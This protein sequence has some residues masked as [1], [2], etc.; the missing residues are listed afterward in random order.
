MLDSENRTYS[1][2]LWSILF[3]S[4][5]KIWATEWDFQQCGICDQQSL[6]SAFAY[7]QSDQSL[8]WLLE[9]SMIIKLL[10]EHRVSKL[11]RRRHWLVWVYTCQNAT[12]L[13]ITYP[14]SIMYWVR[15]IDAQNLCLIGKNLSDNNSYMS[16]CIPLCNLNS[17]H[18]L[19]IR[20]YCCMEFTFKCGMQELQRHWSTSYTRTGQRSAV[21][22]VS[23]YRRVSDCRS[24]GRGF[25]PGPANTLV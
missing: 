22:N 3:T 12:L 11:K 9:Y 13:E 16:L 25:N 5:N 23:D 2:C 24:R 17:W 10:T 18:R 20:R 7:G 6:R 4:Y 15:L 8:C 1:L 21:G 14:G 19:W